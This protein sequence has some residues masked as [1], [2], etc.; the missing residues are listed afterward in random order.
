MRQR[1]SRTKPSARRGRP[2]ASRS[3]TRRG[4]GAATKTTYNGDLYDSK[5]EARY[6]E[7]LDSRLDAGEIARWER[8]IRVRLEVGGKLICTIVVDFLVWDLNNRP[9]Y[10]EVKG[11]ETPVWRIKKRLFEAL[12]PEATYVVV[13]S[14]DALNA[15]LV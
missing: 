4:W 8:Q 9:I 2:A 13:P 6:A 7:Y 3:S 5:S 14:K 1:A 12:H 11:H 15:R 10:T